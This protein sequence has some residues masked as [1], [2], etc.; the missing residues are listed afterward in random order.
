MD[1][2]Y[3]V[4]G[5]GMGHA[6]RSDVIARGLQRAGHRIQF[7]CSE[8]RAL[9]YL[10]SRW[11]DVVCVPG[12]RL[13]VE[14]NRVL[15]TPTLLHNLA[16]Q[17]GSPLDHVA[18][19]LQVRLPDVVLC[20]FDAWTARYAKLVGRPLVAIDNIHFLTRCSHPQAWIEAHKDAAAAA[21]ITAQSTVPEASFYIVLSF[22]RLAGVRQ[23]L[24]ALHLPVVR[25][26]VLRQTARTG[27]HLVAYFN[28]RAD[29]PSILAALQDASP[30]PVRA[31]GRP[32]TASASVVG[33][34]T[35]CPLSEDGLAEDLA[36]CA[37][38]V[39]G[40]GF[41][42]LSEALVLRKPLLAVPFAESFEQI[43]NGRYLQAE[44]YGQWAEKLTSG[45]L[46]DF[47]SRLRPMRER[48]ARFPGA[49]NEQLA[50]SLGRLLVELAA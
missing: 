42:F 4:C 28:D 18:S 47:L 31:Y 46:R 19:G 16:R 9:E 39:G 2:L 50:G 20:D 25:E 48:L 35:L 44:G 43:L 1:V 22:T 26:S 15:P 7:A 34:V 12:F 11:P 45:V 32:G 3:G 5:E 8:G 40:A 13:V 36:S 41:S 30:M 10:R 21:M 29:W 23:P 37:A 49:G 24:T 17:L 27:S 14:D 6:T 33:N 38:A